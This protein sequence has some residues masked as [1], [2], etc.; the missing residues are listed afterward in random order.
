MIS[1]KAYVNRLMH[2]LYVDESGDTGRAGSQ[3]R[4]FTLSGLLVHHAEWH[5]AEPPS[6]G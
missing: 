1:L 3:T 4:T 5:D 6:A 2:L